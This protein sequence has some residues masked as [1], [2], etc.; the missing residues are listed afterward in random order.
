MSTEF[1]EQYAYKESF[2]TEKKEQGYSSPKA[3]QWTVLY[4]KLKL[5]AKN[6]ESAVSEPA[7]PLIL[8]GSIAND[9][10]KHIRL[11]EQLDW[12][13]E[14]NCFSA[15]MVYLESLDSDHWNHCPWA[16]GEDW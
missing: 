2:L 10:E 1:K 13:I 15:A 11:S 3:R 7:R 12:A 4:K 9:T 6:S 16:S 14:N 5:V 8:G